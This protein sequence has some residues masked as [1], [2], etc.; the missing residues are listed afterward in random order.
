[1]ADLGR[2][3]RLWR[4]VPPL[5]R[6]DDGSAQTSAF[7]S[8]SLCV[9]VVERTT[10]DDVRNKY[11]ESHVYEFSVGDAIDAG[12]ERVDDTLEA[13]DDPDHAMILGANT[14]KGSF[15]KALKAKAVCVWPP[16]A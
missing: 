4:R 11:P 9:H 2:A 7:K 3:V 5:Q 16:P 1:M 8:S 14:K 6:N 13:G 12:A 15:G 10:L